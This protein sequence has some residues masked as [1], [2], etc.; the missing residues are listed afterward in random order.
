MSARRSLGVF[1][2]LRGVVV[3]IVFSF[4]KGGMDFEVL[5]AEDDGKIYF[6]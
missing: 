1:F 6:Y 2:L 4:L 3:D 5:M